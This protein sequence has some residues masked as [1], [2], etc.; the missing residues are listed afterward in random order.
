VPDDLKALEKGAREHAGTVASKVADVSMDAL[1]VEPF[2]PEGAGYNEAYGDLI[3]VPPATEEQHRG[4]V[5]EDLSQLPEDV[6][7]EMKKLYGDDV[8]LVLKGRKHPTW[9]QAVEGERKM[10]RRIVKGA[11]G[12]NY[13]VPEVVPEAVEPKPDWKAIKKDRLDAIQAEKARYDKIEEAGKDPYQAH[14]EAG[15]KFSEKE[16]NDLFKKDKLELRR[17]IK[18]ISK[19]KQIKYSKELSAYY[20][21]EE[22][23]Y[24]GTFKEHRE[25][26]QAGT[27]IT[28][29]VYSSE[30]EN[31]NKAVD[32][33]WKL[34]SD[35]GKDVEGIEKRTEDPKSTAIGEMQQTDPFYKDLTTRMGYPEYDRNNPDQ[36]KEAAKYYLK[37]VMDNE[38]L[39]L[40]SAVRSYKAGVR[41]S[42]KGEGSMYYNAFAKIYG[43][44]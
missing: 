8:L 33:I 5:T 3:G 30:K 37:W 34:E 9:D 24:K 4:S 10:G 39:D 7:Q 11:G 43:K 31:L 19:S 16:F 1:T 27:S 25:Q 17:D 23:G 35:R 44:P 29:K 32:A 12:Y 26:A 28:K 36:A 40:A 18:S 20:K 6:Q 38:G 14:V 22:A 2:D 42:K 13:S 15:G 21:A 41:G